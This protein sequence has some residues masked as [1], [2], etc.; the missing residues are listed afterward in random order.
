MLKVVALGC[1]KNLNVDDFANQARIVSAKDFSGLIKC[2]IALLKK[3]QHTSGLIRVDGRLVRLPSSGNAIIIG[4]LHGDIESLTHI[5]K[6]SCFLEKIQKGENVY[7]IFLGDYGDRGSA[8]PEVFYVVLKLKVLFPDKV[9]LMRGNHEGPEDLL[10]V[11]HDLPTKLKQK[12]GEETGAKLYAELRRLFDHLYNAVFIDER[13]ILIHGGV[14]SQAS[15]IEDL[16]YAHAKH[17]K[18]SH[19][20][21]MLWS[22]PQE[23]LK[24]TLPSP[25]GAG[26]LFG[27]DV[28]KRLLKLLNVEVLIR[29][30]EFCQEGVKINHKGKVLTLFSTNKPPYTN[31]YAAY[32]M[33]DLSK[34]IK[35]AYSLKKQIV[36][37]E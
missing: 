31:R 9:I 35:K 15:S 26:S 27:F 19:L 2:A 24:G 22:D 6:D 30:H 3:E 5:L 32:M 33:I 21:E 4:D 12:Y 13:A 20:E 7:L 11:P 25:R 18:E 8:S 36:K 1:L 17:P 14:P 10:P 37:F 28:T 23:N 29:S 34:Q 16:A